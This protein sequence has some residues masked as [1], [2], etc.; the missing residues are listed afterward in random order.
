M[1]R[2]VTNGAGYY[3]YAVV[4]G[5]GDRDY[6]LMG[7]D[8]NR[9]YTVAKGRVAAV[10]SDVP[11]ARIRPERR[12]LAAHQEVL[13]RLLE[14]T[15][16]LPMSFGIIAKDKRAL[17]RI[18][19]QNQKG[20][21]EQLL[22]LEGKFEMGLHVLWDVPNIFEY[23]VLTHPELR[24]ARDLFLGSYREPT[25]E[26]KIEVGRMFDRILQE[27]RETY[28]ES[29]REV[30]NP[31]CS[32]IKN[33]PPRNERE[34]LNLACLVCREEQSAFENGIFEAARLFDHNFT[35]DYNGPWAPHN[36]IEM[37]IRL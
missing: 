26:E 17:S 20:F 22:H 27:D 7:L 5:T 13:R 19:S 24:A 12:H 18:L 6:G 16:P 3:L 10:V 32:E 11:Q 28:S 30:L 31:F 2:Q 15:T 37:K 29:V 4:L 25:Q 23:F 35:F 36:F 14:E 33:N 1:T 34:V 9:V 21:L 8:G